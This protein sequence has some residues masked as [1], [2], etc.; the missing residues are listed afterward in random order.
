MPW[1]SR[2]LEGAIIESRT[3]ASFLV[4]RETLEGL[5]AEKA[6]LVCGAGGFI[7]SHLVKALKKEGYWVRGVDLKFPEFSETAAAA[8]RL[9]KRLYLYA[10]NHYSAKSV[11]NAAMI[12]QQ[13][14]EPIDGEYSPE[15]VERYPELRGIVN[16]TAVRTS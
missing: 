11:A 1:T 15:F 2:T 12:K 14:G 5:M 7:G 10:N 4:G 13:L 6:A 16:V 3:V 8:K 9:V